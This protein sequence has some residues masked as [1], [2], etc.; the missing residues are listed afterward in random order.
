MRSAVI[1]N[2]WMNNA[3]TIT[4]NAGLTQ[5]QAAALVYPELRAWQYWEK[6]DRSVN[7]SCILGTFQYQN[8]YEQYS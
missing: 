5:A 2:H 8:F 6:G 4:L 3:I 7:A 1:S